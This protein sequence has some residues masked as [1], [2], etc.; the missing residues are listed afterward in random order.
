VDYYGNYNVKAARLASLSQSVGAVYIVGEFGPGKNI[1]P[2]PTMATPDEIIS[3]SE[4]NAVGWLAWAWDDNNLANCASDDTWFS[5]TYHCSAY[6][7]ASDLTIYGKDVVL[8]PTYGLSVI[9]KPA[10]GF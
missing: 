8:N 10:S 4:Q 3:A 7:Q 5:M 6:T 9:A 2:S 1:G